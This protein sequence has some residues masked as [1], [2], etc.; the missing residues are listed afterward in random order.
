MSEVTTFGEGFH[1]RWLPLVDG[2]ANTE[3]GSERAQVTVKKEHQ[4]AYAIDAKGVLTY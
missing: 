3:D 4:L 2:D 1:Q